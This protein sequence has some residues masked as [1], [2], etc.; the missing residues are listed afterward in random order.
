MIITIDADKA[1]KK[2]S[3]HSCFIKNKKLRKLETTI[4]GNFL[5]PIVPMKTPQLT[6]YK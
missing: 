6:L 4:K 5:N 1:F 3:T 2:F